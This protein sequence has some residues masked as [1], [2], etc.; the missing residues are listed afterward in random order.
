MISGIGI[1][2]VEKRRVGEALERWDRLFSDRVLTEREAAQ[3]D[4]KGDRIG[5]IAARFAAKEAVFKALGTGW[6]REVGWKDVEVLTDG[7]GRPEVI[8]YRGALRLARGGR[9]RLSISHSHDTAA[10]VAVIETAEED[11]PCEGS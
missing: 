8:L 4:A 2:L 9:V 5:S 3:C 1:D 10:A 7:A 6:S 11:P